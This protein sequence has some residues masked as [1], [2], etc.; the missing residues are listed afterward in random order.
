[1]PS[2]FADW[3]TTPAGVAAE[4]K[5]KI[6]FYAAM[7]FIQN[8][9]FF[10]MYYMI[11]GNIEDSAPCSDLRFWVGFFA[12]DC[13]VESFVC[14]WMGMAGFSDN[15]SAFKVMWVLHLLVAL[16]Y[17]LCTITIPNAIYADEG[18]ACIAA[19][20]GPMLRLEPTFWV[21]CTLFL[22]YVW[23]MLSITYF[24]FLKPSNI[25]NFSKD[26]EK[27]AGTGVLDTDKPQIV[28]YAVMMTIQNFGFFLMYYTMFGYLP[29][30]T[31]CTDLRFWV[32]FFALDC[33]VESFVCVWMAMGGY[34][35]DS[36]LFKV[37]WVLHLLVALPYVL[38]TITIPN[39][40]YADEGQ[41]CIAANAGPLYPLTPTFWVHCA[42]FLV[43][44]WMMLA[45]TFLSFVKPVFFSDATEAEK[46]PLV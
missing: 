16:P 19:N 22:V 14:V 34:T 31:N 35:N 13:F 33:F 46:Q 27:T 6:A 40:I 38:C 45:V 7:M 43:Y 32:A 24:S 15:A 37:M 29:A 17:V 18:Q 39:A 21:H 2:P 20:E 42:L 8:F 3:C 41:K 9:G 5:P 1:M 28:F 11:F 26:S 25:I 36:G 44:V 4:D 12:L 30:D 10:V 23:M